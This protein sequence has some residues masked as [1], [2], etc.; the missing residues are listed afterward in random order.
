VR[1]IRLPGPSP[2]TLTLSLR[3]RE[4]WGLFIDSLRGSGNQIIVSFDKDD[5]LAKS[6]RMRYEADSI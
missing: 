1:E 2:L 5:D 6:H 4:F 3:E